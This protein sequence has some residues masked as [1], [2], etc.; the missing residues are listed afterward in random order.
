MYRDMAFI[1]ERYD[2]IV[3]ISPAEYEWSDVMSYG[4]D[5]TTRETDLVVS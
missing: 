1:A 2:I 4:S 5:I 3:F